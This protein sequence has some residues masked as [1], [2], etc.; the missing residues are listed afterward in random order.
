[1][2]KSNKSFLKIIIAASKEI[3]L[4]LNL[5]RLRWRNRRIV[6]KLSPTQQIAYAIFA[7]KQVLETFE[8]RY[9]E[10]NKSRNAIEAARE[11]LRNPTDN[12]TEAVSNAA[13]AAYV[14]GGLWTS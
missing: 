1:M 6:W 11:Y 9:P 4:H 12:N 8:M 3:P 14:I 13:H 5:F 2:G 7:A 10:N